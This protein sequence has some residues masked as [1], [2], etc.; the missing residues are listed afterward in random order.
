MAV[1]N[2]IDDYICR[3]L[4]K[5]VSNPALL[6]KISTGHCHYFQEIVELKDSDEITIAE[7]GYGG[8]DGERGWRDHLHIEPKHIELDT[9]MGHLAFLV[10]QTPEYS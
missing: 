6:S 7:C 10:L 4:I 5:N 3:L 1:Y 8:D 9:M 2:D